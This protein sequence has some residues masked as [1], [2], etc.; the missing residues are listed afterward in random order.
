MIT[1]DQAAGH[2]DET[3]SFA[4]KP[5]EVIK[6]LEAKGYVFDQANAQNRL[7]ATGTTYDKDARV[8]QVFKYYF[9][10]ATTIVTPDNPKTP[11]DPLPDNP[12]KNYPAGVTKDDL[13]KKIK[14]TINIT[15]LDGK[16]QI[17]TQ[18]AEFTR[19]ATVDEVTGEI[20]YG[21]WS[22]NVVLSS[23]DVPNIP[24]YEPS[25]TVPEI[26][27]T[28]DDHDMTVNITYKK[29][30]SD[31]ATDQGDQSKPSNGG[32]ITNDNVVASQATNDKATT[33]Q[34]S[35]PSQ[36]K[37]NSNAQ[38]LPQTGN[39]NDEKSVLGLVG[40]ML[41]AGLGLGFGSKKKRKEN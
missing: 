29:I 22:K 32:Q 18:T 41:A 24:G 17:I 15:T 1:T 4:K 31:K 35:Q 9:K 28:P 8:D 20:T 6:D 16:T 19:T 14:R 3:I 2:T 39:A 25:A 34:T 21:P 30:D 26:M 5:S 10:H 12:G 40:A 11:A 33:N 36:A 38:Q 7:L 37:D 23:V 27:V 13:N